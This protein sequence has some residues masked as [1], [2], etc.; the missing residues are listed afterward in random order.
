[1]KHTSGFHTVKG[2]M[3]RCNGRWGIEGLVR[4]KEDVLRTDADGRNHVID[5]RE[6]GDFIGEIELLRKTS[7]GASV[8]ARTPL[9]VLSLPH[10]AFPGLLRDI[11]QLA[12]N[13]RARGGRTRGKHGQRTQPM[14]FSASAHCA[15]DAPRPRC[16]TSLRPLP[17]A[18]RDPSQLRTCHHSLSHLH[19]LDNTVK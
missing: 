19:H 16:T 4:G 7:R 15:E 9:L 8:R 11:P 10:D 2:A 5:T 1:M 3:W 14:G 18:S 12:A 17:P 6:D 13:D